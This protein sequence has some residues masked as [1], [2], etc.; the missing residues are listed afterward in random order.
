MS[1]TSHI[2]FFRLTPVITEKDKNKGPSP[3]EI[4]ANIPPEICSGCGESYSGAEKLKNCA[5]CRAARYCSR[6]CQVS[7]WPTHKPLCGGSVSSTDIHLKLAKKLMANVD[8]MF[9]LKVYTVLALDLLTTP[10]NALNTCLIVKLITRDADHMAALRAMM[11]GEERGLGTPIMLQIASIEKKP[12]LSHTTAAMRTSIDK[13]R[14]GIPSPDWPIVM[15]LFTG[16]DVNC[17]ATPCVID[18]QALQQG[19]ERNPFVIQ[20][21]MMGRQE[22]P[23]EEK[24]IIEQF[25]NKIYMDKQNRYLLHTKSK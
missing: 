8:L 14:A 3:E 7:D 17:L 1:A 9:Y 12:L 4:R 24:T 23:V 20:S 13:T 5:G 11:N 19:R 6:H 25:N 18:P 10:E 16:D 22:I 21:A 15:I 2:Q